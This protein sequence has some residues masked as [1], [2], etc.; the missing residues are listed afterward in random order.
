M[1]C[2][3]S[4]FSCICWFTIL[5]VGGVGGGGGGGYFPRKCLKGNTNFS[6]DMQLFPLVLYSICW[7]T[8][9][10]VGGDGGGGGGGDGG[11]VAVVYSLRKC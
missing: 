8:I 10:A 9:L 11:A 2:N 7:F 1:L 5:A 6:N 3:Y 4:H